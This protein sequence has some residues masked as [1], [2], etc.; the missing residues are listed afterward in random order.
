MAIVKKWIK[1]LAAGIMVLI[2]AACGNQW[3]QPSLE[4]DLDAAV[5]KVINSNEGTGQGTALFRMSQIARFD[6]D[7]VY[8]FGPDRNAADMQKQ[9]GLEWKEAEAV[10]EQNDVNAIVFVQDKQVVRFVLHPVD[11]GEFEDLD[12]P[13]NP[14]TAVFISEKQ[15]NGQWLIKPVNSGGN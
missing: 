5:Q 11:R 12:S 2:L 14:G 13:R 9:M 10:S 3:P 15:E 4:Q 6:W 8:V 1:R 7:E